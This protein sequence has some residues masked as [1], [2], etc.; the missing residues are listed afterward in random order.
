MLEVWV[1]QQLSSICWGTGNPAGMH[2]R[3]LTEYL[4]SPNRALKFSKILEFHPLQSILES[5][6]ICCQQGTLVTAKQ[7]DALVQEEVRQ[8]WLRLSHRWRCLLFWRRV[9]SPPLILSGSLTNMPTGMFPGW[10]WGHS[11]WQS[12][13]VITIGVMI[14]ISCQLG[15]VCNYLG[16]GLLSPMGDNLVML[17]DVGGLIWIVGGTVLWAGNPRLCEV[18]RACWTLA[19]L[20]L[21]CF[22]VVDLIWPAASNFCRHGFPALKVYTLNHELK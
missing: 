7:R 3:K 11:I 1:V 20:C 12:R 6:G 18:E 13:L 10:F 14:S 9:F 17:R 21:R 4:C 2:P 16:N 22:L 15:R 19:Y 5:P 8:C